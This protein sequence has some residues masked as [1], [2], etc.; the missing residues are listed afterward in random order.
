MAP[1]L[2]LRPEEEL[3]L[4]RP[5]EELLLLLRP[6]PVVVRAHVPTPAELQARKLPDVYT[7]THLT[8]MNVVFLAG[9]V[10]IRA[11]YHRAALTA[12][13]CSQIPKMTTGN[14]SMPRSP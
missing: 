8:L 4:L 7:C 11:P 1:L 10:I 6:R 13:K 14:C 2:L 9:A 12:A 3:L 5:E